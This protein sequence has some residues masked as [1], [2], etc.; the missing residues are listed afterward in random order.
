MRLGIHLIRTGII[1]ANLRTLNGSFRLSHIDELIARKLAGPEKSTLP[2]ADV[3]FHES[4]YVRLRAELQ[5]A[6]E[7]S[8]LPENT[9]AKPALNDLL[10]RLRLAQIGVATL[11]SAAPG[12]G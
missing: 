10:R 3:P 2:D 7:S 1:E 6:F 11:Q 8:S 5:S 12:S 9:Y 4:E